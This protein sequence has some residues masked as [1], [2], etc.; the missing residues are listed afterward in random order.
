MAPKG[1]NKIYGLKRE[2][3]LVA[4]KSQFLRHV[5]GLHRASST[6]KT[7]AR[8]CFR[9]KMMHPQPAAVSG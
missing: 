7:P 8:D 4:K 9:T 2:K 5:A 6:Q 1:V 3:R